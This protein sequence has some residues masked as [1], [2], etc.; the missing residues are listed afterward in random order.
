MAACNDLGAP[1]AWKTPLLKTGVRIDRNGDH[2]ISVRPSTALLGALAHF[3][4]Y[5][6][7]DAKIATALE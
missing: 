1:M 4:F 7:L 6:G 5:P 2:D 3:T